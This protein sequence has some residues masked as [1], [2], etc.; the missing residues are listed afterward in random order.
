MKVIK[1]N[2]KNLRSV[3]LRLDEEIMLEVD[4]AAKKNELSRQ[5]LIESI[6]KQV[7]NDKKFIL[8]IKD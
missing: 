5:K 7:L 1:E 8:R 2:K 6:L 4:E 3:T